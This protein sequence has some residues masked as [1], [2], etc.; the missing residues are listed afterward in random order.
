MPKGDEGEDYT[1]S[2]GVRTKR[3][4][5]LFAVHR[6][7]EVKRKLLDY[8]SKIGSGKL[9]KGQMI[10]EAEMLYE[11]MLAAGWSKRYYHD[12]MIAIY[13]AVGNTKKASG[14]FRKMQELG[15]KPGP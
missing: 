10:N 11:E 6:E 12:L 7:K 15:A 14:V 9:N 2:G 8:R 1:R 4:T 3:T 13:A 5:A